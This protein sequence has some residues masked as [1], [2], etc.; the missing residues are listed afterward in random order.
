MIWGR[1]LIAGTARVLSAIL[2]LVIATGLLIR[3]LADLQY[4]D[5]PDNAQIPF[6]RDN[7]TLSRA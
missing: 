3:Q 4:P 1:L 7:D 6:F 2:S 5:W